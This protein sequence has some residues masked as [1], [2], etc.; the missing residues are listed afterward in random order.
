MTD[1]IKDSKL[2]IVLDMS[3]FDTFRACEAKYH[4]RYVRNKQTPERAVPLDRGTLV[5]LAEEI[6]WEGIKA[7][8]PFEDNVVAALSAVR[9]MGVIETGLEIDDIVAVV[10][11]MEE[12]FH[13]WKTDDYKFEVVDVEKPFIY[14][15]HESDDWRLYL[16]G[17]IDL[18]VSDNRYLNLPYDHK[19][20]ERTYPTGRMANQFRNYCCAVGSQ[21]LVVNKIG[22]QKTLPPEKKFLRIMLTYDQPYMDKWKLNMI[23]SIEHYLSCAADDYWPMNETSCNKFNKVC[24]YYEVCDASDVRDAEYKLMTMF[25]DGEPWDVTKNL[26]KTSEAILELH[27]V[28]PL[29]DKR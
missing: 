29:K 17:K 25:V 1:I 5:H 24:E 4:K 14:L 18:I 13:F 15:F 27:S 3:Q 10:D 8:R 11:V 28:G 26:K 12:N 16:T 23:A 20:F 22:F 9:K 21:F 7:G 6:Y 2:N 19:S